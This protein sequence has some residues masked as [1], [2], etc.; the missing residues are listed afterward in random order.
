MFFIMP[1]SGYLFAEVVIQFWL[2]FVVID[3]G[4]VYFGN[5]QFIVGSHFTGRPAVIKV[6]HHNICHPN[7]RPYNARPARTRGSVVIRLML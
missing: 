1:S 5:V 4:C 7:T 2:M 6:R 3:Q